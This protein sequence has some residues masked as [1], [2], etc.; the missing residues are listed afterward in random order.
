MKLSLFSVAAL[1]ACAGCGSRDDPAP[2]MPPEVHW[3]GTD[4]GYQNVTSA[5]AAPKPPTTE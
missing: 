3:H 5:G 4:S 1:A 2:A